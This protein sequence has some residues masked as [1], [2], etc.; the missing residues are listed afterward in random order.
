MFVLINVN[1]LIDG[2]QLLRN[3]I[4][5]TSYIYVYP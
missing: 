4:R 3:D 2:V 5:I 1:N